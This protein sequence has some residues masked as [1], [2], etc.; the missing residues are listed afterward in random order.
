MYM[1]LRDGSI[2]VKIEVDTHRPLKTSFFFKV[3]GRHGLVKDNFKI[4]GLAL[5]PIFYPEAARARPRSE[6]A[7]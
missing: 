3:V 1:K 2:I 7:V 4:S 5:D 6:W